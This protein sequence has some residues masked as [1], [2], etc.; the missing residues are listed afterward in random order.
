MG[1]CPL[2]LF[3]A[4]I[5]SVR[6]ET[7]SVFN[8]GHVH[9]SLTFSGKARSPSGAREYDLSLPVNVRLE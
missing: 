7:K 5:I 4:V 2:K 8:V 3:T 6:C 1:T 9:L